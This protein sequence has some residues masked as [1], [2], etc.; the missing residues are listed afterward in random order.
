[1]FHLRNKYGI[2]DFIK[3]SH[4]IVNDDMVRNFGVATSDSCVFIKRKEYS[5]Y[6]HAKRDHGSDFVCQRG[7][8]IDIP[9]KIVYIRKGELKPKKVMARPTAK[10]IALR[11]AAKNLPQDELT[12]RA[13]K[14][15][16]DFGVYDKDLFYDTS[17]LV[18]FPELGRD[19]SIELWH[20]GIKYFTAR[21]TVPSD[22]PDDMLNDPILII[23][24]PY[25]HSEGVGGQIENIRLLVAP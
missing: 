4:E 2:K 14:H 1:M 11:A 23:F 17:Q 20:R 15:L 6:S 16:A 22:F 12:K 21:I 7:R 25:I 3:E 19:G 5:I 24:R 8:S 18:S 13:T 10:N 9:M